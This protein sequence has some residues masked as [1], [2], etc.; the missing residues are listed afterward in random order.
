MKITEILILLRVIASESFTL[1][2]ILPSPKW[3]TST[4][5][6]EKTDLLQTGIIPGVKEG[7]EI[8]DFGKC[9]VDYA[10]NTAIRI[11]GVVRKEKGIKAE[12]LSMQHFKAVQKIDGELQ[13]SLTVLAEG[14][15]V[16]MYKDPGETVVKETEYGP[17]EAAKAV[18][19]IIK[20][21]QS[22]ERLVINLL[23]GK[24][25]NLNEVLEAVEKV[26][27]EMTNAGEI[28]FNSISFKEFKTGYTYMTC[29]SMEKLPEFFYGDDMLGPVTGEVYLNEGCYVTVSYDDAVF[30]NKNDEI[31]EGE[32]LSKE[33]LTNVAIAYF[34]RIKE[35]SPADEGKVKQELKEEI[36]E[37]IV[38][39]LEGV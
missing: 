22:S 35:K 15:G 38:K 36:G 7:D 1:Q 10:E 29:V 31:Y 3:T 26:A 27:T 19:K 24:D 11:Q 18:L 12:C 34:K 5:L 4:T 39:E 9:G 33:E 8:V 21:D 16:E 30:L 23:S 2:P 6:D 13:P 32:D 20:K 14:V 37:W 17:D 25:V 28:Y